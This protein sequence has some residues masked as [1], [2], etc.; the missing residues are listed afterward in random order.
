MPSKPHTDRERHTVTAQ[1]Y[2]GSNK[3]GQRRMWPTM[4][5]NYIEGFNEEEKVELVLKVCPVTKKKN[6]KLELG[7]V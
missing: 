1:R 5:S 4:P 2:C 3:Y 6:K 7:R